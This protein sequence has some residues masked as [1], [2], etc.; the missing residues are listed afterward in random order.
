MLYQA[1]QSL[2]EDVLRKVKRQTIKLEAY[3]QLQVH[4]RGRGL[5]STFR[6]DSRAAGRALATHPAPWTSSST[7]CGPAAQ[8]A[9]LDAQ[10]L[11][12]GAAGAASSSA[13]I[14]DSVCAPRILACTAGDKVFDFEEIVVGTD[15]LSFDD[16]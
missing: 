8:P 4:M 15:S 3:E 16:I 12:D 10:G 13:S 1:V 6:P 11:R 7:P 14:R 9:G 2:D 5:R